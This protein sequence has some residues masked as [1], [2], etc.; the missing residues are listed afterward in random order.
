MALC[1]KER[2]FSW[3]E[4]YDVFDENET[5]LYTV[6]G[7][8]FSLGHKIHILNAKG[9]E[10]AYIH[11]KVWSFLKKYELYL[12]GELKGTIKEKFSFIHPKFAVDFLDCRIEGDIL[13]WNYQMFKKDVPMAMIQRKILSWGNVFYLSYTDPED[14]LAVLALAIAVDCSEHDNEAEAISSAS[15]YY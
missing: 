13:G 7:E 9:E 3:S 2:I 11:E 15:Y 5:L 1:I 10:V 4:S 14:E 12:H 6:R 8:V